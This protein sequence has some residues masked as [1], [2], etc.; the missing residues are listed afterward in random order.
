M[1]VTGTTLLPDEDQPAL[2]TTDDQIDVDR[3][4]QI[5]N[6]GHIRLQVREQG[7]SSW[8]STAAGWYEDTL[9]YDT[10]T[11][12]VLNR[13]EDTTYELQLRS[14]T[15]YVNGEW[16]ATVSATTEFPNPRFQSWRQRR[17]P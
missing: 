17:T 11:T 2:S 12:T 14:E 6:N 5:T 3:E 7:E 16:T 9:A 4:T 8:D 13:D 10:L 15:P 1:P